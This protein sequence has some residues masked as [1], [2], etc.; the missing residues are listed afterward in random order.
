MILSLQNRV[1]LDVIDHQNDIVIRYTDILLA[2]IGA[3]TDRFN[4][5]KTPQESIKEILF[6]TSQFAVGHEA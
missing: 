6:Y 2:N 1:S 4:S 5:N 3:T